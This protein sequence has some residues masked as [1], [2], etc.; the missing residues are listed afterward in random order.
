[1][2]QH[3]LCNILKICIH[4]SLIV[5]IVL[6]IGCGEK[7]NRDII[8][9][10]AAIVRADYAAAQAA[11]EK[12]DPGNQE[13]RYLKAF[14]Q[15][16]TRTETES[17]HQAIVQSNAY[18]ETLAADIL[19]ISLQ[20]DPDSDEL[21]RQE[22]LVR[23]QNSISGLFVVSL[24]E[25]VEKRAELLSELVAHPDAAVVIGL[26]AA[27]KCYQSNALE[28]VSELKAK[29]GDGE[30]VVELLRQAM[31]HKD[32]AIQ[33]EALSVISARCE[34]LNSSQFLKR[35]WLPK[36]KVPLKSPIEQLSRL[37]NPWVQLLKVPPLCRDS[38]LLSETTA[39]RYGCTPLNSSEV[40]KQKRLFPISS[41]FSQIPT[42]TSKIPP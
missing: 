13:A 7:E 4:L 21:D 42:V 29:L 3:L 36:R 15:N 10:R 12:T 35:F 20:E 6:V 38:N 8:E 9:A 23:S 5:A 40:H 1:M 41:D 33:K 28:A 24:A 31:H 11:V 19:A 25:A 27:E 32:T 17:W 26:L 39:R 2:K 16:R 34:T 18:L 37:N 30:A 22:R 14:L